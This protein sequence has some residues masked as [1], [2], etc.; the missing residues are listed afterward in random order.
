M[1]VRLESYLKT[2][3]SKIT[4][5]EYINKRNTRIRNLCYLNPLIKNDKHKQA[6]LKEIASIILAHKV[7][8]Q[9]LMKEGNENKRVKFLNAI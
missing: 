3:N 5:D 8:M 4:K 6:E 7:S 9:R 2:I 1:S